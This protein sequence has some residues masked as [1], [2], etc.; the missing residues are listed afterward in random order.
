MILVKK[1]GVSHV[2][3]V[4]SI[5]RMPEHIISVKDLRD[6]NLEDLLSREPVKID[7]NVVSDFIDHRSILVTG[8]AG[9]IGSEIIRQLLR[10]HPKKVVAYEI[11]ETE[12]HNLR[13]EINRTRLTYGKKSGTGIYSWR[14]K[15][16]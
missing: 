4:P 15:R 5:N 2:K 3:I 8:G 11:D 9:S 10:F 16:Y 14:Y 12:L 6:I 7:L 13:L 1:Y